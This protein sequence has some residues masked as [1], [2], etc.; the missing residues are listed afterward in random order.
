M[1][2]K[3]TTQY[4]FGPCPSP[5][6]WHNPEGWTAEQVRALAKKHW[7]KT[8]RIHDLRLLCRDEIGERAEL[9]PEIG[10]RFHVNHEGLNPKI[11]YFTTVP[12]G[13]LP[14][15][16]R[17][18]FPECAPYGWSRE[19]GERI[20]VPDGYELVP[21]GVPFGEEQLHL[22]TRDGHIFRP[23]TA[24]RGPWK[25]DEIDAVFRKTPSKSKRFVPF[26]SMDDLPEPLKFGPL[27]ARLTSGPV[28]TRLTFGPAR[29]TG[30]WWT[31]VSMD[32]KGFKT[33]LDADP[34]S[35]EEA[36]DE[37]WQ[38]SPDRKDWFECGKEAV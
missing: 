1:I 37:G 25:R 19:T 30:G 34:I 36:Y 38:L 21:E 26:K 18:N 8:L 32:S 28:F 13:K 16:T 27:F 17:Y 35:W 15:V 3:T 24:F 33:H 2:A 11:T 10:S 4:E 29:L 22:H 23:Y 5:H 31:V 14:P 20:P 6:G 7:P 9:S 12:Y